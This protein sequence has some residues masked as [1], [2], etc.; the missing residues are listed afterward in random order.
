[1]SCQC[2]QPSAHLIVRHDFTAPFSRS[3]LFDSGTKLGHLG[4]IALVND[5]LRDTPVINL[6]QT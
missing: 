6:D 4:I 2:Q 3:R 5:L 1:M